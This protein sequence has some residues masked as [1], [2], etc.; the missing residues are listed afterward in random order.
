MGIAGSIVDQSLFESYLG[1]R[2]EA[3]DMSEFTRRIEEEIFDKEEF[4]RALK[5]TKKNCKE[6]REYNQPEKQ[7]SRDQKD[8]DWETVVKMAIIG[9][10]LMSWQSK[11]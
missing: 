8:K 4:D 9:R 10:D 3:I 2:V 7:R 6:G 11:T 5:W 1:M